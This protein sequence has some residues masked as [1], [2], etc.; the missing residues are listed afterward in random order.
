MFS[1]HVEPLNWK[2]FMITT[3][4][5]ARALYIEKMG[6][7]LGAR[8]DALWQEVALLHLR[9]AEFAKLFGTKPRID[10]LNQAAPSFFRIGHIAA[11]SAIADIAR[12]ISSVSRR[13]QTR[14]IPR[15][16]LEGYFGAC[17]TMGAWCRE[18][19]QAS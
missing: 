12:P 16:E 9:W 5:E 2:H 4:D 7:Q 3:S 14:Q 17:G 8:F 10:L 6:E 18:R 15:I 11:Y 19:S 13:L 1:H